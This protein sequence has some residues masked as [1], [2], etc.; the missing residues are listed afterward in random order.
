MS[1][2]TYLVVIYDVY[3]VHCRLHCSVVCLLANFGLQ[4]TQR[5]PNGSL[6]LILVQYIEYKMIASIMCRVRFYF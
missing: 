5:T 4:A 1:F 3:F 6:C 2:P